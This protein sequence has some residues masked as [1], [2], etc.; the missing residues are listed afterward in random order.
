VTPVAY[1]FIVIFLFLTGVFAFY[2]GAFFET[3]QAD[4]EPFFS[5]SS[6]ALFIFNTRHINASLVRRA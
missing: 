4:L 2:I 5:I 6:V 3:N 1:V